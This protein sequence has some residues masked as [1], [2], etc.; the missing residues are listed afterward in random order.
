LRADTIDFTE[1]GAT[2]V[3]PGTVLNLSNVTLTSF[4]DAFFVGAPG[5]FGELNNLAFDGAILLGSQTI[6]TNGVVDFSGFGT[7][8]KLY[9]ADSSTVRGIGWGDFEFKTK[10]I[11]EPTSVLV[12]AAAGLIGSVRRRTTCSART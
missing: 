4:G 7:I 10:P 9:F 5:E 1:I 3:V 12:L 6:T 11:P 2:G 8:D